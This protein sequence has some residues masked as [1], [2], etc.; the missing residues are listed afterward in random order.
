MAPGVCFFL[1]RSAVDGAVEIAAGGDGRRLVELLAASL[2][3]IM[4]IFR[5][6]LRLEGIAP[7]KDNIASSQSVA[8]A[9]GF[10]QMPF[11]RV[12]RHVRGE[13]AIAP[14]DVASIM[15]GYLE[16]MEKLVA[17]LDRYGG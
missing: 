3:T 4:V 11:E 14:Q 5:A 10:D 17:H 12:V 8:R 15:A 7:P 13:Q 2:S 16:G 9:A 6:V 1:S